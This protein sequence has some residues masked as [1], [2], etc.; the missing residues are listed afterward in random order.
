MERFDIATG[1]FG[2]AWE[3]LRKLHCYIARIEWAEQQVKVALGDLGGYEVQ[4]GPLNES[5]R[6]MPSKPAGASL[7]SISSASAAIVDAVG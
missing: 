7:P 5:G 2:Q 3:R 6:S 1:D 4:Y